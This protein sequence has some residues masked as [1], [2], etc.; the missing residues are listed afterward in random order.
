MQ[1][2]HETIAIVCSDRATTIVVATDVGSYVLPWALTLTDIQA[3]L[4]VAHTSG[5]FTVD[6]NVAGS[7]ILSTKLTIDANELSS[8]TAATPYAFAPFTA[9][10]IRSKVVQIPKGSKLSVDVDDDG[11]GGT[12]KGLIV[13]FI[14]WRHL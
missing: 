8:I 5:T 11:S 3:Q 2:I 13:T 1:Y 14:G 6:A 12:P 7:T 9:T 10:T 4:L